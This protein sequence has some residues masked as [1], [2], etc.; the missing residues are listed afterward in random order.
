MHEVHKFNAS[1]RVV[2]VGGVCDHAA[3]A[4]QHRGGSSY[5][6]LTQLS[7]ARRGSTS[8]PLS[9]RRRI[10]PLAN[11][12]T[13]G[14]PSIFVLPPFSPHTRQH[15]ISHLEPPSHTLLQRSIHPQ[16]V[17]F[18]GHPAAAT[19]RRARACNECVR[20]QTVNFDVLECHKNLD[21]IS[22]SLMDQRIFVQMANGT[23][24]RLT[25]ITTSQQL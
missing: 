6:V 25:L 21:K 10:V 22:S 2:G 16:S 7:A 14:P 15:L 4:L 18:S 3:A 20:W 11:S 8:H 17:H 23:R 13:T 1:V 12:P 19:A 5:L 9:V 24:S